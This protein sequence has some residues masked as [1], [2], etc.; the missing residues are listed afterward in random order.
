MAENKTISQIKVGN[1]IYDIKSNNEY[2]VNY[3]EA[4]ES[5]KFSPV[6]DN[7]LI[8]KTEVNNETN[9]YTGTIKSVNG[10]AAID[11]L[12]KFN[13]LLNNGGDPTDSLPS[14]SIVWY[15]PPRDINGKAVHI[16]SDGAAEYTTSIFKIYIFYLPFYFYVDPIQIQSIVP[17]YSYSGGTGEKTV[18]WTQFMLLTD[19]SGIN[20]DIPDDNWSFR[21][22][23]TKL[24]G[25]LA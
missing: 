12:S 23:T 8:T 5:L 6:I 18:Y 21:I 24:T 4:N 2:G 9:F 14:G 16:N 3:D 11:I 22:F 13:S 7:R 1:E 25:K 15:Q 19:P 20:Q 10:V 17:I